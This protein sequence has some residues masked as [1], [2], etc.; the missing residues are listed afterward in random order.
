MDIRVLIKDI[1]VAF[2]AQ[3]AV[4]LCSV[5]MSFFVPKVLGVVDYA[6]WQL[7]IF[8]TSYISLFQFGLNDGVYLRNGGISRERIDKSLI[9]SQLF[10][11]LIYQA[12]IAVAIV[13]F[14]ILMS[15]GAERSFVMVSCAALLVISNANYYLGYVFQAMK[16]TLSIRKSY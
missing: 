10:V 8:Y 2:A 12:L 13:A 14:S 11:G 7:F 1:A 15:E 5:I 4:F 16:E 9:K 3:G 6:Y